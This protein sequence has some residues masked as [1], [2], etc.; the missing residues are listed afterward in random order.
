MKKCLVI[1]AGFSGVSAAC[2]LAKE[3]YDVT[4]IE[5]NEGVGGRASVIE[6]K[7]FVF[8]MGPSWYW[9]PDVLEQFFSDFGKQTSDYYE[10]VRLNPSYRVVFRNSVIDVPAEFESLKEVFEKLEKGSGKKLEDFMSE[11]RYKY[12]VGMKK[13]VY[14]PCESWWEFADWQL[15]KGVLKLD[16]F[17]SMR[18]HVRKYFRHP[19]LIRLMEFPVIFLGGHAGQIPALY[20]LMN[21]ADS[22]LGSWYP[23]GGMSMIP[24]AMFKLAKSMGVEFIFNQEV[25]EI[26]IR[27]NVCSE[28][29][30][31][32]GVFPCDAVISS[33]DYYHTERNLLDKSYWHHSDAYWSGRVLAPSCLLF[34]VG[35][36][37]KIPGL[38]HHTLFFDEDF[39]AHVNKIYNNPSWPEKPLFYLSAPSV[40]DPSVAPTGKENLFFLIPVA[41]GLDEISDYQKQDYF[42]FMCKKLNKITQI[43]IEPH[44]EYLR[45]F[46]ISDFKARYHAFKGNAYGLA[47]TLFQTAHLKPGMRHK[48]IKNLFFA[49]QL[50]IP[51]P[52]VPPAIISGKLAARQVIKLFS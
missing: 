50:T 27:N 3:G 41:S 12:E 47:N 4:V 15:L 7:G 6:E 35:L 9:M 2:Y 48:K 19:D 13:L 23:M 46:S 24:K 28:V 10:L 32:S 30:T 36:N 22:V 17:I 38:T 11:A 49:G 18:R 43:N 1:G 42:L 20:S 14:L 52:G 21:Y 34:Y 40:T 44:V 33:A 39:D 29:V 37:R 16:V 25:K 26:R 45:T 8:D 5:K 51:G 31:D